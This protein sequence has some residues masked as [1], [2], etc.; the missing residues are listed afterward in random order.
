[1]SL[2]GRKTRPRK[3]RWIS[4]ILEPPSPIGF[5]FFMFFKMEPPTSSNYFFL[6]HSWGSLE[7]I[8]I[9]SSLSI[10]SFDFHINLFICISL[11]SLFLQYNVRRSAVHMDHFVT[12]AGIINFFFIIIMFFKEEISLIPKGSIFICGFKKK[13]KNFPLH[14]K[15]LSINHFTNFFQFLALNL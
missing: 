9:Q 11:N 7:E 13:K 3:V 10:L 4:K 1:M 5:V 2:M 14:S 6:H 12:Q 15:F 8:F